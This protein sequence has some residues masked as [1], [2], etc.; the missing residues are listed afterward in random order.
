MNFKEK[1]KN[2]AT[3]TGRGLLIAAEAM[4]DVPLRTRISEIDEEIERLQEEKSNLEAKLI[5]KR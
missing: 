2:A 5:H 4:N 3:A 1:A